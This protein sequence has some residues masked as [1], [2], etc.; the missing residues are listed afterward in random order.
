MVRL[1]LFPEDGQCFPRSAE[2]LETKLGNTNTNQA[3]VRSELNTARAECGTQRSLVSGMDFQVE[4]VAAEESALSL[5]SAS[6]MAAL[7]AALRLCMSV[8]G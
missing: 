4:M 6:D 3:H 8:A 2:S 1:L 5:S 7:D